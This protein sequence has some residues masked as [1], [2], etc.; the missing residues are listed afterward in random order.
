MSQTLKSEI[1]DG[2]CVLTMNRPEKL[3][4]FTYEMLGEWTDI[5]TSL[6]DRDD[7]RIVVI[8]GEG[9]AFSTGGD[10]KGFAAV[11]ASA[12]HEIKREVAHMQGL[13]TAIYEHPKPTIAAINGVA[14]GGGLD[15]ALA[16]D[17]RFVARD[18]KLAETYVRMGLVPGGGGA[19]LL[20]RIVGTAK[21]LEM[22][23]SAEFITGEEAERIGLANRAVPADRLLEVTVEFAR[24][25]ANG[26]PISVQAIKRMVRLGES[27][28]LRLGL[29]L[30]SS[31]LAMVRK[32][33]DHMIAV[34]AFKT[35]TKPEFVGR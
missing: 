33:E 31:A 20:P 6:A 18:A 4:S 16:C 28:N 23:L 26:A 15:V 30:A 11:A 29:E 19:F 22:L 17:M 27:Q 13:T 5:I 9:S 32:T 34:E 10:I 35:K 25:I 8:T 21:A 2:V 3:N 24:K 12:P 7:V 1:S 14:T